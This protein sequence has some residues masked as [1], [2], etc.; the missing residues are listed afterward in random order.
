MN[1]LILDNLFII[2]Y[3]ISLI[4]SIIRYRRYY[5]SAL[6]YLPIIIGYTLANEILGGMIKYYNEIQIVYSEGYALNN[7]LIFNIWDN[8]F[9]LYFFYVYWKMFN[10]IK[11]KKIAR[12]GTLLYIG[13]SIVNLFIQDF[14]IFTQIYSLVFG[15][16]LIVI[17][18][19]LYFVELKR[20][21][22]SI[23]ISKNLLFWI[24]I[25]LLIF[26]TFY[27]FIIILITNYFYEIY[28][29]LNIRPFH[30]SLIILMYSCF[31][32]GFIRMRRIR[33][34]SVKLGDKV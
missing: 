29:P 20:K 10:T 17:I 9:F 6:K 2:L 23:P 4:T 14:F 24:S 18:A 7:N 19:I 32:I 8:I 31:I 34:S 25:G 28:K 27:P 30:L 11:F 12:N 22:T 21:P 15:S 33:G 13:I 26:Y 3:A 16:L 5:D 1:N